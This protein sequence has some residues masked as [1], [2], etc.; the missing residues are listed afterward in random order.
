MTLRL[1]IK[2]EKTEEELQF[3]GFILSVHEYLGW[4]IVAWQK[5]VEG[6]LFRVYS[7]WSTYEFCEEC[8]YAEVV[9]YGTD[10]PSIEGN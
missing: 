3:F 10:N 8:V 5:Q 1:Y 2:E 9:D 4:I 6:F 7:S